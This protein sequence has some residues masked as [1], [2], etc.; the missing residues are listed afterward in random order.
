MNYWVP[1]P[2]TFDRLH[3]EAPWW[4]SPGASH[5]IIGVL[6][7]LGLLVTSPQ[8]DQA[9]AS[10]RLVCD[11]ED[12][13]EWVREAERAQRVSQ[14]Q[15]HLEPTTPSFHITT[16][17]NRGEKFPPLNSRPQI[18]SA[19]WPVLMTA[20]VT[21]EISGQPLFFAPEDDVTSVPDSQQTEV[22]VVRVAELCHNITRYSPV[23]CR[24]YV[25][26]LNLFFR[27]WI[28]EIHAWHDF[29]VSPWDEIVYWLTAPPNIE[30]DDAQDAME[31]SSGRK[32]TNTKEINNIF[33]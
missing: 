30:D 27:F 32:N 22:A 24:T 6:Y 16:L 33:P 12:E 21:E 5:V 15:Q 25:Q 9:V 11:A 4:F 17:R 26:L 7:S 1:K 29:H 18:L 8:L 13:E 23:G 28:S 3:R 10:Y 31:E 19:L 2:V 14:Q 20:N